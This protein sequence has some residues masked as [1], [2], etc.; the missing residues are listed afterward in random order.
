MFQEKPPKIASQAAE[1]R[2]AKRHMSVFLL[3]KVTTEDR[4]S[5]GR[6][7]NLSQT[8]AKIET[9]LSFT[10]G[11]PLVLE[12]RS[13]LKVAG[14]VRWVAEK[15]IGILFDKEIDVERFLSR[16]QPSCVAKN[17]GHRDTSAIPTRAFPL[18][19]K[20][21]SSRFGMFRCPAQALQAKPVSIPERMCW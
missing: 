20:S 5:L 4:Q 6:V 2:T 16:E 18:K 15:S 11:D 3:A 1:R 19:P 12:I 9:R 17:R 10:P 21:P 13:D 8:G 7:L 14:T